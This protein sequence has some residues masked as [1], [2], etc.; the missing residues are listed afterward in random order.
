MRA[1]TSLFGWE[2]QATKLAKYVTDICWRSLL[3][4]CSLFRTTAKRM[5]MHV[6]PYTSELHGTP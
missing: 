3:R 1:L 2:R 4:F 5:V 6:A